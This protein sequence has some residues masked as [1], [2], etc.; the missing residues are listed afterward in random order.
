MC[1]IDWQLGRLI[2]PVIHK[3]SGLT[4]SIH[5]T[6]NQQR[7]SVLVGMQYLGGDPTLD[8]LLVKV[9]ANT[10]ITQGSDHPPYM[11]TIKDYGSLV[12]GDIVVSASLDSLNVT[13]VEF[14]LPEDYLGIP[15]EEFFKRYMPWK[16]QL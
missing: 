8:S 2:R 1:L 11:M 7:I 6:P 12:S 4:A 13:V 16:N 15:L 10:I 14:T 9:G 5:L 3:L